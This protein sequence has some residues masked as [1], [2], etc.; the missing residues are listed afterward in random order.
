[1]LD[2]HQ[3]QQH[4]FRMMTTEPVGK[5]VDRLAVP[6]VVCMLITAFY[7]IVDTFF[8]GMLGP[9]AT[10]AV[11]VTY[12]FMMVLQAIGFGFG[13]GSGNYISQKLGAR[14]VKA[15]ATMAAVGAVSSFSAGFV[16]MVLGLCFMDSLITLLGSTATIHPYAAQYIFY[17]LLG[18]PFFACSLTLNNQLRLQGNARQALSGIAFGA[19]LNCVLDPLFIFGLQMGVGG[20]GLSTFISQVTSFIILIIVGGRS[21]AVN[22]R[23]RH[24]H[25]SRKLYVA[26]FQGG[27]P[28]LSRQ[29]VNCVSNILTNHAM[30][31]FGDDLFAA[32]TIVIRIANFI[33]AA[34][35]GIGQGFQPVC[36]FNYGAQRY[37]RVHEAYLHTQRVAFVFLMLLTAVFLIWTPTIIGLFTDKAEVVRLG[38][39]AGRWQCLSLP[40]MGVCVISS[41]LFQNINHYKKATI[42]AL[43]RSGI[44][45]IPAI[46]LLPSLWRTTG[47]MLAQP[48]ADLCTFALAAPLQSKILKELKQQKSMVD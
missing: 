11:G 20:A 2:P 18:A 23:L 32:M 9:S 21:D 19:I 39:V 35:A 42:I 29:S 36:G 47:V 46:L 15:A 30:K 8:I 7:N 13:H 48:I 38:I 24:F 40:C 37:R 12:A 22:L 17:V 26:M 14:D 5:L 28:S 25:P 41:M 1:M 10:G 4:K 45:F 33:F 3:S 27:L 44:F 34:I 43:S 31:L 6:T 16:I